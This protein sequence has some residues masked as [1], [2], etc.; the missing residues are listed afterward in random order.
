MHQKREL[1]PRPTLGEL[2]RTTPW[3]WLWCE[4]CQHHAPLA[5][6]VPVVRAGAQTCRATGYASAPAALAVAGKARRSS[7]RAGRTITLDLS[8]FRLAASRHPHEFELC[9]IRSGVA[10]IWHTENE[11]YA[12]LPWTLPKP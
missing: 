12:M 2:Q 4:R 7:V 9:S 6:A 10:F 11:I 1:G 8:R 3:I 5:C